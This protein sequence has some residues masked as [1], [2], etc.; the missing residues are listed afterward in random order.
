M[1]VSLAFVPAD[2]LYGV[3]ESLQDIM[4][5]ELEE[6]TNYF[7]DTWIS[8]PFRRRKRDAVFKPEFWSVLTGFKETY[9]RLTIH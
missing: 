5:Q 6:L 8:R 2:T 7:E 3:F 1:S 4:P 9:R